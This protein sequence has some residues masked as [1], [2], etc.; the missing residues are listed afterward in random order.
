MERPLHTQPA[1]PDGCVSCLLRLLDVDNL[2]AVLVA[3]VCVS[4]LAPQNRI[5]SPLS[6]S[7]NSLTA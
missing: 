5:P 2:L 6:L 7:P 3:G 4:P 1:L